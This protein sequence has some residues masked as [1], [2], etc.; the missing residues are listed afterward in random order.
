VKAHLDELQQ[1]GA[2]PPM[3]GSQIFLGQ[4]AEDCGLTD[5]QPFYTN[6]R[7]IALLAA[8][9]RAFHRNTT[10]HLSDLDAFAARIGQL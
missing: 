4:L 10:K 2:L 6:R 3:R 5:R 7:I 9:R 8:F 1:K